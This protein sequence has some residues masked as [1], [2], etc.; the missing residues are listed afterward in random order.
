MICIL[1]I[2]PVIIFA[3]SIAISFPSTTKR[4]LL[5]ELRYQ[6]MESSSLATYNYMVKYARAYGIW[7]GWLSERRTKLR[8]EGK[9]F[10]FHKHDFFF[11]FFCFM[12]PY[13]FID[14]H[15]FGGEA[16]AC[17]L[18][19]KILESEHQRVAVVSEAFFQGHMK[20]Y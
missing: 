8:P 11:I 5:E 7:V 6:C 2:C 14:R 12:L 20:L 9:I 18:K 1:L 19:R 17:I 3:S 13:V 16:L 4:L 15:S 10:C